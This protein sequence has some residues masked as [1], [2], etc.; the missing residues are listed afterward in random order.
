M[1]TQPPRSPRHDARV[2]L[3][4]ILLLALLLSLGLVAGCG[5]DDQPEPAPASGPGLPSQADLK[6]YFEAIT[7]A[8]PDALATAQSD[9]AA[10]GSPAE[11]FSSSL[12]PDTSVIASTTG[13]TDRR[14]SLTRASC[15]APGDA[16]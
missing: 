8:D 1:L 11:G 3:R 9:I 4:G 6:S 2:R 16:V 15:P 13:T 12:H 5:G 10:D 14:R 7:G